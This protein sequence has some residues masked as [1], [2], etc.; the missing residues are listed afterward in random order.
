M[1]ESTLTPAPVKTVTLPLAKKSA[2]R[3]TA[4][5]G[6]IRFA[7]GDEAAVCGRPGTAIRM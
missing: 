1:P 7:D 4:S 2:S 5:E 6:G 3:W